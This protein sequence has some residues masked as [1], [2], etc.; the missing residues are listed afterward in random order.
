MV[1]IRC[2]SPGASGDASDFNHCGELRPASPTDTLA[3]ASPPSSWPCSRDCR[4]PSGPCPSYRT[5]F[6][7]QQRGPRRGGEP[8]KL[9][10]PTGKYRDA[11]DT[12]GR[13]LILDREL[14]LPRPAGW[15][16]AMGRGS[17]AGNGAWAGAGVNY[18]GDAFRTTASPPE[19][20]LYAEEPGE[21]WKREFPLPGFWGCGL[22]QRPAACGPDAL[23]QKGMSHVRPSR[24]TVQLWVWPEA[25]QPFDSGKGPPPSEGEVSAHWHRPNG[26][27]RAT[28]W[29]REGFTIGPGWSWAPEGTTAGLLAAG[30]GWRF[31]VTASQGRLAYYRVLWPPHT[32][33]AATGPAGPGQLRRARHQRPGLRTARHRQDPR[34]LRPG[35]G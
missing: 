27:A 32:P 23:E 15:R 31:S 6:C 20:R 24:A 7:H 29:P 8:A 25:G 33:E 9:L 4:M 21:R 17:W 30:P 11:T 12:R 26:A 1:R 22:R 34:P 35:P 10:T 28:V 5:N 13:T 3:L 2:T 19:I 14:Y 18:Q 16:D